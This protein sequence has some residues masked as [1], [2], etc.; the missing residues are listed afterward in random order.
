LDVAAQEALLAQAQASLPPLQKQFAQQRDMLKALVGRFPSDQP[1]ETFELASLQ[2]PEDLPV[3]LPSKLV[4]QRPDIRAAEGALH[5]A[6][7]QIGVAIANML[8]NVTLS[9]NGGYAAN[10]FGGLFG[11]GTSF[12]ALAASATQPLFEGSTLL[13]RTRAARAAFDQAAAQY[14]S[15]VIAAFQNVADDLNAVQ[16]DAKALT[17]TVAAEGA[18]EATLN[19]TRRQLDLGQVAYLALLNAQQAYQQARI[20]RVQAQANRY[21]DT[22]ALFQALGGGWWNRRDVAST[23]ERVEPFRARDRRLEAAEG[24]TGGR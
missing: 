11:P 7:A 15:T 12:W 20:S 24:L 2:L 5:S 14:R 23:H 16:S 9:A 17:A 3:T 19:I 18:A 1:T 4:E 13:H 22:A 6:S 21:A 8:P 10:G